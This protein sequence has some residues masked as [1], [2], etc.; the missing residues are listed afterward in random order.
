LLVRPYSCLLPLRC[1][2]LGATALRVCASCR[3]QVLPEI[4]LPLFSAPAIHTVRLSPVP[5][6]VSLSELSERY[7]VPAS[8]QLT[9]CVTDGRIFGLHMD[10]ALALWRF[11][12]PRS[13]RA[14]SSVLCK[15]R[16]Q[17]EFFA[18]RAAGPATPKKHICFLEVTFFFPPSFW[19]IPSKRYGPP[20][21]WKW[22]ITCDHLCIPRIQPVFDSDSVLSSLSRLV[23]DR[24][25]NSLRERPGTVLFMCSLCSVLWSF[26]A[27]V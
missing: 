11:F 17:K 24:T 3:W 14:W 5:F 27:G 10:F 25:Y 20:N 1:C 16:H 21:N 22:V 26:C 9:S 2:S 13:S 12:R 15:K 23:F 18:L 7:Q 6:L 4:L 19:S 8:N